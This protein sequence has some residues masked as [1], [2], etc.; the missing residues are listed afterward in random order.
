VKGEVFAREGKVD[1]ANDIENSNCHFIRELPVFADLA[2][3]QVQV[4]LHGYLLMDLDFSFKVLPHRLR[5]IA[6][7][8]S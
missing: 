4:Y 7:I 3:D 2:Y 5:V 8:Q 6:G 1:E